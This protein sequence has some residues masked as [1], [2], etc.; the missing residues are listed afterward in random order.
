MPTPLAEALLAALPAEQRARFDGPDLQGELS[1][2]VSASRQQWPDFPISDESFVAHVARVM[3]RDSEQLQTLEQLHGGDL[4][5]ACACAQGFPLAIEACER[6]YR[7]QAEAALRRLDLPVSMQQEVLQRL[8]ERLFVARPSE[9]PY[10]AAYSGRG[11]LDSWVRVI[12]LRLALKLLRSQRRE[13]PLDVELSEL[14]ARVPLAAGD[15]DPELQHMKRLYRAEISQALS[16]AVAQLSAEQREILLKYYVAGQTIDQLAVV[17]V[18]HRATAARRVHRAREA[19]MHGVRRQLM[20]RLRA[21]EDTCRSI[22]RLMQTTLDLSAPDL[23]PLSD[24]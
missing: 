8:R 23:G 24:G 14:A 12:A 22:L 1:A 3:A 11:R 10:I 2:L 6:Q 5:L 19:L 4:L 7:R 15:D 21:G 13:Q 18:V 16:V 20:E 17:L 9:L